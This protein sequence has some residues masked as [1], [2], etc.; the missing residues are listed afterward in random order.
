[1]YAAIGTYILVCLSVLNVLEG[2]V[3]F[4]KDMSMNVV[5][6]PIITPSQNNVVP[7]G[8]LRPLGKLVQTSRL[9]G[10]T[11][12]CFL[13]IRYKIC[14]IV[15]IYEMFIYS[16][17][18]IKS[19]YFYNSLGSKYVFYLHSRQ[20]IFQYYLHFIKFVSIVISLWVKLF[21]IFT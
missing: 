9:I 11:Y 18:Y 17:P 12:I 14:C 4:P 20:E 19:K 15:P 1:M 6:P 13:I 5:F 21:S 3:G 10:K 7:T 16:H 8:H 2:K